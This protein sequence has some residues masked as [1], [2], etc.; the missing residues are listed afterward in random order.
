[1]LRSPFGVPPDTRP[2]EMRDALRADI[3]KRLRGACLGWSEQDFQKLV[4]SA[5]S[6]ALKYIPNSP[7]RNH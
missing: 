6:I 3:E 2:E 5:A 4:D 7:A 1:M